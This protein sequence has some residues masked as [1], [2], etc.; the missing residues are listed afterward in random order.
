[1]CQA[2]GLLGV[3][4]EVRLA[5]KVRGVA[6]DLDGVLVRAHGT[7][8]T[9]APDFH[10]RLSGG[11]RVDF[12]GN[13]QGG[14]GYVVHDAD[15]EIVLGGFSL[16]VFVD[17]QNLTGRGILG[18]EAVTSADDLHRNAPLLV[19]GANVLIQRLAHRTRFLGTVQN[20]KALAGLGNRIQEVVR[21]EGTVEVDVH[22]T[23]FFTL[24]GQIVHGFLG[25][26]GGGAH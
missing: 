26:L 24:C 13:G 22:Q 6:D 7:V 4:D 10:V 18:A 25:S 5:V 2:A 20:G 3:V 23:D 9:H 14:K 19:D 16:E 15:G 12:L 1:M 21:G 11:S 8:R 17:R